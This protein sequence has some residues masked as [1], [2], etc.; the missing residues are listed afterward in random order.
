MLLMP[1]WL[2]L[3]LR[4]PPNLLLLLF[5][6]LAASLA[7]LVPVLP[8]FVVNKTTV[9]H[10]PQERGQERRPPQPRMLSTDCGR[11]DVG[12]LPRQ[13]RQQP[14]PVRAEQPPRRRSDELRRPQPASTLCSAAAS[15]SR[16][17]RNRHRQQEV[18][19][20]RSPLVSFG[21]KGKFPRRI[22]LRRFFKRNDELFFLASICTSIE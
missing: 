17:A 13:P 11:R 19:R 21:T 15:A 5:G 6:P 2:P 1:N 4:R 18:K 9:V 22:G 16:R 8:V 20:A 12:C 10:K 3:S 14:R 7:S